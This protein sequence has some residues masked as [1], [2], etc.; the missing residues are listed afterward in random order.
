MGGRGRQ[1]RHRQRS[2]SLRPAW[3]TEFS[4]RNE[5]TQRN[6][7]KKIKKKQINKNDAEILEKDVSFGVLLTV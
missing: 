6:P 5:A 7:F 4:R 2:V 1:S 3:S